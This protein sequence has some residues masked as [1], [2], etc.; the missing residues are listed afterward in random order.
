MA[1]GHQAND[2]QRCYKQAFTVGGSLQ[3][4]GGNPTADGIGFTRFD[5]ALAEQ[6]V[7]TGVCWTDIKFG[8]CQVGRS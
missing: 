5:D 3:A 4:F 8:K 2:S 6:H 1:S 7:N